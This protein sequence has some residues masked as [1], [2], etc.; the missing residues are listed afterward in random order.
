[1]RALCA[2]DFHGRTAR[3]ERFIAAYRTHEPDV[4]FLA[5]DLGNVDPALFVEVTVPAL[6]VH[7]NMDG[8]LDTLRGVVDFIDGAEANVDGLNVLGIGASCPDPI[9]RR[10]DVILT[11]VPP[12]RTRDRTVFGTHIGSR[13]LRETVEEL[14]PAFVLCGHVHEDFGCT[15]LGETT[16]VNCSVGKR[17]T[18]ML[19]SFETGGVTP[20][21]Y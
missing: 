2:A 17:G 11:H 13:Q 15:A 21:G 8:P 7:G 10:P 4:V 16:V 9:R 12:Y 6:A 3:Y 1:M 19:L 14:Q 5:G 20:I 18:G